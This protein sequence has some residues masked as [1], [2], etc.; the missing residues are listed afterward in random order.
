MALDNPHPSDEAKRIAVDLGVHTHWSARTWIWPVDAALRL[1]LTPQDIYGSM[2][3][4]VLWWAVDY[5][6]SQLKRERR[7]E[8]PGVPG[9]TA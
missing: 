7:D 3:P 5:A 2:S 4:R 1:G 8:R 9:F 6:Y